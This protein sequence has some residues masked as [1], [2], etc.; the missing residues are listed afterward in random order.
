MAKGFQQAIEG[1]VKN[2]YTAYTPSGARVIELAQKHG[3]PLINGKFQAGAPG[4]MDPRGTVDIELQWGSGWANE[5]KVGRFEQ[6]A[7]ALEAVEAYTNDVHKEANKSLYTDMN[8]YGRG[9][10]TH[11]TN[12][13]QDNIKGPIFAEISKYATQGLDMDGWQYKP[14]N[15][16]AQIYAEHAEQIIKPY[17]SLVSDIDKIKDENTV[18]LEELSIVTS[19]VNNDDE[20]KPLIENSENNLLEIVVDI[21]GKEF[22]DGHTDSDFA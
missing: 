4:I 1:L 8:V 9:M 18:R 10:F 19:E 5:D 12:L 2:T 22:N 17:A 20:T 16:V 21:S 7:K 6:F 13:K 3:I 11:I 14:D 15:K